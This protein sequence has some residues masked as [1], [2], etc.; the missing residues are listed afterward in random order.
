MSLSTPAL[1]VLVG[2]VLAIATI[3]MPIKQDP[4]YEEMPYNFLAR[5]RI[6]AIVLMPMILTIYTINC[7][8]ECNCNI[9]TWFVSITAFVFS[10]I[11]FIMSMYNKFFILDRLS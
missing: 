5:L 2:F 10:L 1:V 4:R 3:F 9:W 11:L 6:L 7:M 8:V